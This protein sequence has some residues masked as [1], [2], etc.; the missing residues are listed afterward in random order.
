[1]PL[2][3]LRV[4]GSDAA[5]MWYNVGQGRL[6]QPVKMDVLI[7][8]CALFFFGEKNSCQRGPA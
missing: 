1:L 7:Q 5:A 4:S 2:L 6:Q 3:A 8:M